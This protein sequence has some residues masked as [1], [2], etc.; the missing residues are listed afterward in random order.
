MYSLSAQRARRRSCDTFHFAELRGDSK[1]RLP[2]R[3]NRVCP[4]GA[5][6]YLGQTRALTTHPATNS[7]PALDA[8]RGI[9][10]TLRGGGFSLRFFRSVA[11]SHRRVLRG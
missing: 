8:R 9:N 2:A 3:L 11:A 1:R 10:A 7:R 5:P 4:R 6:T